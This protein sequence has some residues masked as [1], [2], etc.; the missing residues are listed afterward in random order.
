[1]FYEAGEFSQTIG[2]H[3][4]IRNKSNSNSPKLEI[5]SV[6]SSALSGGEV[7]IYFVFLGECCNAVFV[8]KLQKNVLWSRKLYLTLHQHVGE[9]VL[10]EFVFLDELTL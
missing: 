3:V 2:E 4:L 1:M 6:H 8:V 9:Q 7:S 10:T 5:H